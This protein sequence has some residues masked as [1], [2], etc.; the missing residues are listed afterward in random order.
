MIWILIK[1]RSIWSVCFIFVIPR[2]EPGLWSVFTFMK[3][4]V[5]VDLRHVVN[6]RTRR[7]S[8]QLTMGNMGMRRRNYPLLQRKLWRVL[9]F[10]R[11]LSETLLA[12]VE[13]L[14]CFDIPMIYQDWISKRIN[15]VA[16]KQSKTSW[17]FSY[18]LMTFHWQSFCIEFSNFICYFT[19]DNKPPNQVTVKITVVNYRS[20]VAVATSSGN[21]TKRLKWRI[22]VQEIFCNCSSFQ[23]NLRLAQRSIP[24][25]D[26]V[27]CTT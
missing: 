18:A 14:L 6:E 3:W 24:P 17:I 16:N 13:K 7:S 2:H 22:T 15:T 10:V 20:G 21:L 27:D 9:F 11:N 25:C 19:Y 4:T 8:S 23:H 1:S 12:L 26:Q 5:H